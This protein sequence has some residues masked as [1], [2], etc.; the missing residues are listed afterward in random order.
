MILPSSD[1]SDSITQ[2]TQD[3]LPHLDILTLPKNDYAQMNTLAQQLNLD[4]DDAYQYSIAKS[5]GLKLVTLDKDF[6][7]LNL[8]DV[9]VIFLPQYLNG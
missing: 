1:G 7:N 9:N 5:Y 2:F 3:M 4:F 6:K 8:N